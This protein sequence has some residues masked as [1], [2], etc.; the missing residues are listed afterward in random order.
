MSILHFYLFQPGSGTGNPGTGVEI[1]ATD[2][3]HGH[4]GSGLQ[5]GKAGSRNSRLGNWRGG[6][7]SD[8]ERPSVDLQFHYTLLQ[9]ERSNGSHG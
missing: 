3:E 5:C 9:R 6:F 4:Y 8:A 1:A 2:R 7:R